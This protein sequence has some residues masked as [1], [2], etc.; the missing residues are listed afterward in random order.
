VFR[1]SLKG[2]KHLPYQQNTTSLPVSVSVLEVASK[3]LSYRT[4]SE[5]GM[6]PSE[7][8]CGRTLDSGTIGACVSVQD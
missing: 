3:D 5:A 7:L 2:D 6:A 1:A 4:R 8:R